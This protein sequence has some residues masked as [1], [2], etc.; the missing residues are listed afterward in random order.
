MLWTLGLNEALDVSGIHQLGPQLSGT[1]LICCCLH[2][3]FTKLWESAKAG[4]EWSVM[5]DLFST[6][7]LWYR[8][9]QS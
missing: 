3:F 8:C 1:K 5:I 7:E 9:L 6:S 2:F 4:E